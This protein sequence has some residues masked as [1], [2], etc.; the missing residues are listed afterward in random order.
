M[1]SETKVLGLG[2]AALAVL[3]GGIVDFVVRATS[4][5]AVY[6]SNQYLCSGLLKETVETLDTRLS[7]L[8]KNSASAEEIAALKRLKDVFKRDVKYVE[9]SSTCWAAG[10][11]L[12]PSF[13]ITAMAVYAFW[14]YMALQ[15]HRGLLLD[16]PAAPAPAL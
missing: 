12:F 16:I 11:F 5:T 4:G 2:V 9:V 7:L 14:R 10:T 13:G 15:K 3:D 6:C 8:E 1:T